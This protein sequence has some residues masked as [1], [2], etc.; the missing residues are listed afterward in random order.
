[1]T[2]GFDAAELF[3]RLHEAGVRYVV[4]GGFAVI[5]YGAQRALERVP[6]SGSATLFD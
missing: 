6:G 1:M 5:A 4:I 2:S 3:A